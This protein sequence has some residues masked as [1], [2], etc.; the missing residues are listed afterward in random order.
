ML[1]YFTS[2]LSAQKNMFFLLLI[3]M[4]LRRLCLIVVF[5]LKH[6][7]VTSAFILYITC[8]DTDIYYVPVRAQLFFSL[9]AQQ[10]PKMYKHTEKT[11][12]D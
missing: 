3:F 7:V 6:V 8:L 12:A 9:F 2:L 5:N 1:K 10:I 11:V 4:E